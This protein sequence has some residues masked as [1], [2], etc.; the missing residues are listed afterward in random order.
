MH[1]SLGPHGAECSQQQLN[2]YWGLGRTSNQQ[3]WRL[4]LFKL[5]RGLL[6]VLIVRIEQIPVELQE[7]IMNILSTVCN[8]DSCRQGALLIL[9]G[10][11]NSMT[12]ETVQGIAPTI[13]NVIQ[14]TINDQSS[15]GQSYSF[16]LMSKRF[17]TGLIQD[18]A[19]LMEMDISQYLN[20]VT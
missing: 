16:D 10:M 18:L 17:A 8:R 4:N 13:I 3:L 14:T 15:T 6:Q 11:L 19:N 2:V 1:D 12:K 7:K 9:N 20:E 5:Y